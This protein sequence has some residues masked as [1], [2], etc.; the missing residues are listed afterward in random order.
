M[1]DY[2]EEAIPERDPSYR[3]PADIEDSPTQRTL[4]PDTRDRMQVKL[5]RLGMAPGRAAAVAAI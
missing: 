5:E 4:R 3:L 2:S 1:H